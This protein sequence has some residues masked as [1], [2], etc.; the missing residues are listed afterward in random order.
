LAGTGSGRF[1]RVTFYLLVLNLLVLAVGVG[2]PYL[3]AARAPDLNEINAG[4]IRF[5]SQPDAYKPGARAQAAQ[6][7]PAGLCLEITPLSQ[8]HYQELRGLLKDAGLSGGQC[9]YRLDMAP[10]WWVYWP[11][12]YEAARRDRAIRAIQ[13][14]GV[15]DFLP[16]AQGPMAQSFSLGVFA[17]EAQANQFRDE[18]R[19]RGLD[20]AE[21]GPRPNVATGRLGCQSDDTAKLAGF[22]ASLPAWAKTVEDDFCGLPGRG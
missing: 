22:R 18:M 19:G 21:F 6:P 16:I 15:K 3:L 1:G 7:A 10:G 5:W 13:A 17:S 12:E 9:A 11:P 2:V 8:A 20:K 14:A 4:K